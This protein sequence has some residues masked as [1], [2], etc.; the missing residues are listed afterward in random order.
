MAMQILELP[1]GGRDRRVDVH[2]DHPRQGCKRTPC[3]HRLGN[4]DKER[5]HWH[6]HVRRKMK[7]ALVERPDS[8]RTA[9]S[10]WRE[11][12]RIARFA[13]HPLRI[14]KAEG[15]LFGLGL[16][17][18]KKGANRPPQDGDGRI[19]LGLLREKAPHI[20]EPHRRDQEHVETRWMVGGVDDLL[21]GNIVEPVN[22]KLD[23]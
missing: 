15:T 3:V 17:R 12:D 1:L 11:K 8:I 7:R 22:T 4:I 5:H 21:V 9:G 14:S 10:F 6:L 2:I 23:T 13:Q 20:G 16:R 19:L 18:R